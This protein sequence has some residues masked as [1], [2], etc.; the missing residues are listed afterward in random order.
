MN[1]LLRFRY[2]RFKHF[3]VFLTILTLASA[4]FSF[5]AL[6]F[7]GFY[8]SFNAYLGEDQNVIAVYNRQSRTP[9]T[10]TLPAYLTNQVSAVN[11]VLGCSPETIT[12]CMVNEQVFFIRGVIPQEFST[13][14]AV[15][16]IE[17]NYLRL[18][19]L[20]SIILGVRLADRLNVNLYDRVLVFGVLADQ[21][22]ELQVSG[23][24]LANSS[25]DD[26]CLVLLNVGQF[27][28]GVSYNYVSLIRVK[29][30]PDVVS[31]DIIYEE[32][33]NKAV[34]PSGTSKSTFDQSPKYREILPWST[35]TFLMSELGVGSPQ[36]FMQSYLDKYGVTEQTLILLSVVVCF[37]V[38]ATVLFAAQTFLQQHRGEISVLRS[39]GASKRTLKLD[40]FCKVFPW[41]FASAGVGLLVAILF[42]SVLQEFVSLSILSHN[43]TF[44]PSPTVL[45]MCFVL[46]SA[47]ASLSIAFLEIK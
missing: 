28:R 18:T 26:E 42:L 6:S 24:Y 35:A 38:S 39:M 15:K 12:P 30:N 32:L 10:G 14:N 9:F 20:N 43:V 17:G 23:I 3:L 2:L 45:L 29:I 19:D 8:N 1:C 22:V 7:L 21:Y 31:S 16:M 13:L 4:L 27:L 25:M 37:F 44:S 46:M 41:S 34:Q 47:L 36:R 5:T 11:G 33:V 40:I